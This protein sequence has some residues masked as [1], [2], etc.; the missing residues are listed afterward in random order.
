LAES[1]RG[2]LCSVGLVAGDLV[3]DFSVLIYLVSRCLSS[4][5]DFQPQASTNGQRS[6]SV[7]YQWETQKIR[8]VLVF[9]V[10][11]SLANSC[12][13]CW[14]YQTC[15]PGIQLRA[16]ESE[17]MRS[18]WLLRSWPRGQLHGSPRHILQTWTTGP[19]EY[20]WSLLCSLPLLISAIFG[21]Y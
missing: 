16:L 3:A 6:V 5:A 12:K 8:E 19:L 11:S 18:I 10:L 21:L 17:R 2:F 13:T 7:G 20:C 1:F 15:A 9:D 14:I 4:P